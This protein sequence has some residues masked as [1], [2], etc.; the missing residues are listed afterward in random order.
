MNNL[1]STFDDPVSDN[2]LV[3]ES[4]S[5]YTSSDDD[6][7]ISTSKTQHTVKFLSYILTNNPKH[8]VLLKI[9]AISNAFTLTRGLDN[10]EHHINNNTDDSS[11]AGGHVEHNDTY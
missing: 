3:S 8:E 9:K 6:L 10:T 7:S 2:D 4:D 1:L 11:V 5:D